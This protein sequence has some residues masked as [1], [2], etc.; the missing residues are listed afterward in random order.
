MRVWKFGND[1]DTDVIIPGKYLVYYDPKELAKHA[2][3]GTRNDFAREVQPG[4]IVVAGR[5][6]GSGSSREHAP[7]ALKGA[8][9]QYIVAESFARIFFRNAINIGLLPLVCADTSAIADGAQGQLD[10]LK[11]ELVID[12]KVY[13]LE[14]LPA[15]VRDIVN[16]GGLVEFA[17]IA[18]LGMQECTVSRQ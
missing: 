9:V 17:R 16:A 1:V 3:E 8:G 13:E 6:F 4:D 18:Q 7:L 5:N 12:G 11:S 14:P 15:F 2:F 10:P